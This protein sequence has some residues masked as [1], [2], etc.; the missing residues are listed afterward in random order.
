MKTK[1]KRNLNEGDIL[2]W[3]GMQVVRIS[4]VPG[5]AKWLY[6]QTIPLVEEE[7]NPYDWA[8]MW[9]YDRFISDRSIID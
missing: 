5:F 9:D 6:G 2:D 4:A 3:H 7:E 8:Y 1:T